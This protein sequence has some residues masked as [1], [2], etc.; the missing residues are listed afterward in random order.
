MRIRANNNFTGFLDLSAEERLQEKNPLEK[1]PFRLTV[2]PGQ[3]VYVDDKYRF[4]HS[5]QSA[6]R[7]GYIEILAH[8]ILRIHVGT[9]A[10]Q[11]PQINDLWVQI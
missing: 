9:T 6:I 2:K 7:A 11:H 3:E 5:I 1:C 10:P 8:E 4:L